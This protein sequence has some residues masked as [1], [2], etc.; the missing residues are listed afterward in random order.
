MIG[1]G[2]LE[3]LKEYDVVTFCHDPYL[4]EDRARRLATRP[5]SLE[6]LFSECDLV[7]LHA[8][9]IP[10]TAGMITGEHFRRMKEGSVFINTA[11]GRIVREGEMI[12]VLR[13]G[14]ILAFIDVTD[15]EPPEADSP[16]YT[17]P[18]VFLTPHIAG[19]VGDEVRR[20]G[21]LV[22]QE[23]RRFLNGEPP[24]HPVTRDMMAWLA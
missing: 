23:L 11:R 9:S 2:V 15:P 21:E 3:R 20:Q 24:L 17:L 5:A 6:E 18:N 1:S 13:E 19:P 10:E 12:E 4:S 16:L 7:T 8:A 14:K 22:L